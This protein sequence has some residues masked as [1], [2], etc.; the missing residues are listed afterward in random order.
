MLL[1]KAP[2]LTRCDSSE[3]K[4][5]CSALGWHLKSEVL[6]LPLLR[7]SWWLMG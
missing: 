4:F 5:K 3:V 1:A 7:G 2:G 6:S